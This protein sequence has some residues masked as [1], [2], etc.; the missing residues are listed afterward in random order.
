MIG[1]TISHYEIQEKLGEGGMGVVY[2]A[3]D[4][5]LDRS[6]A[7]KFL[8]AEVMN[9]PVRRQRFV[10][11]A[12]SASALSHP[13]IVTI[14]DVEEADGHHFVAMELLEGQDLRQRIGQ[15]PLPTAEIFD[16]AVQITDALNAAH[17]KGIVHRDIKPA[18]IF[19]TPRGQAKL[20]DFGL[21]KQTLLE[22]PRQAEKTTRTVS[23]GMTAPGSAMGTVAYMSPEQARGEPI[24]ARTDLFSLGAVLYEMAT[25]KQAFGGSTTA[26][27][28]D[29]LLN[30]QPDR[31]TESNPDVPAGL[32]RIIERALQKKREA[33][34]ASAAEMLEE[35][36]L[37]QEA[38]STPQR[39]SLPR[40]L[41]TR[42][43]NPWVAL[44]TVLVLAVSSIGGYALWNARRASTGPGTP[45]SRR[46][47]GCIGE[48]APP[49]RRR[50][51]RSRGSGRE[52][53]S[54]TTRS[55][56]S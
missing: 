27:V 47:S 41:L 56:P 49:G 26:V 17:E 35:L 18:N 2:K 11:E 21:A 16:L 54:P 50:G 4:L 32:V 9:D 33:R 5:R 7:L 42:L 34:Y 36:R 45:R 43:R 53:T 38:W 52:G 31:V 1:R 51:L 12:R 39:V 44:T 3:R 46:S 6:V 15:T 48:Y 37:C 22:T 10:H 25:G 30:R 19:V 40:L 8:P 23:M 13:H 20:L 29:R 14:Y 28:F 55:S 24:D